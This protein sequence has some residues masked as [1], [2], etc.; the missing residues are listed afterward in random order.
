[1]Q[2]P[3]LLSTA[4]LLTRA[5][6]GSCA[7]TFEGR[8]PPNATSAL[9]SS[10]ESPFNPKYVLGKNISWDQVISFPDVQP[11]ILDAV[12]QTKPI[13]IKI[14][15]ASIFSSSSEGPETALRR[16]E[17]LVNNRPSTVSGTK[18]WF[19][20]LRTSPARPLNYTHEYLLAFHEAADYQADFWSLKTGVPMTGSYGEIIG[21]RNASVE[22]GVQNWMG[23]GRVLYLQGYKWASP[24]QT[25]F[26]TPFYPDTWHNFGI[27]LDFNSNHLQVLYSTDNNPLHLVTP[28]LPNNLSGKAPTT[29]GETHFGIQKKPVG[30]NLTN[31]L[32]EGEQELGVREGLL[33]GGI[34]QI[35]GFPMGCNFSFVQIRSKA[36]D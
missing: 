26:L 3:F 4:S 17:L 34:S 28:L 11:S 32:Y 12:A 1:M 27:Y 35:E 30:A 20:S 18:T 33:M 10:A 24:V 5:V 23:E 25:F 14:T 2:I 22:G 9:F 19:L 29:L 6:A 8:I 36:I 13:E 7:P 31:F 21:F 15:D 16:A